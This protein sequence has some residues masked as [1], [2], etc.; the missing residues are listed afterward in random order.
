MENPKNQSV[1]FAAPGGIQSSNG[2]PALVQHESSPTRDQTLR[3]RNKGMDLQDLS[4]KIW[5]DMVLP[6]I[7]SIDTICSNL[8]IEY[9]L[10]FSMDFQT[11]AIAARV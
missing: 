5:T 3:F 6:G 4:N 8:M 9:R 7:Q 2:I 10:H 1:R 11:D